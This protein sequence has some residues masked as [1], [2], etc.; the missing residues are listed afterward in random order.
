MEISVLSAQCCCEPKT[1]LR[2]KAYKK[3]STEKY[4]IR[5]P[6]P[7]G[8]VATQVMNKTKQHEMP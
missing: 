8:K 1:A 3:L 6:S 4:I 7:L 2:N 5:L